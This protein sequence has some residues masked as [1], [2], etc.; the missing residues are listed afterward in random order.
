MKIN[1]I[2]LMGCWL[3]VVGS[4]LLVAGLDCPVTRTTQWLAGA[5]ETGILTDNR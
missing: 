2:Y 5:H 1:G 4:W 3:S